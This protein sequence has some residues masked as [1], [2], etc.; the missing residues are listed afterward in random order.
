M[1]DV[2]ISPQHMRAQVRQACSRSSLYVDVAC[3][4]AARHALE[5][6]VRADYTMQAFWPP[7]GAPLTASALAELHGSEHSLILAQDV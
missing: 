3:A 5:V 1:R 7:E 6:R 2:P 4:R